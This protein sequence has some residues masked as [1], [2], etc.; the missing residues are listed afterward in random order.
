V[1]VYFAA[2]RAVPAAYS[3][4]ANAAIVVAMMLPFSARLASHS[5]LGVVAGVFGGLTVAALYL[6]PLLRKTGLFSVSSLLAARFPS[7]AP[8]F[9]LIGAVALSSALLAVAGVEIAVEALID[10]AGASRF[11]AA[12]LV[13][14]SSLIIA[15]SGGL[16]GVAWCAAGAAGIALFGLGWPLTALA[17]HGGVPGGLLS[18][19]AGWREAAAL[20]A[21]WRVAPRTESIGVGLGSTLAVAS[22]VASLAPVLAPFV[23]TRAAEDSRRSGYAALF[24]SV[25]LAALAATAVAAAALTLAGAVKGQSA[26]RLPAS[27]YEAGGRGQISI[28]GA[29]VAGASAAQRACAARGLTPGAPLQ[30]A[31]VRPIDGN[32][33]LGALPDATDIGAAASGLLASAVA[34]L[35]LALAAAGLQSCA[36][37]VGHDALYS[38]RGEVDLTSRRLALSRLTLV[39]VSAVAFIIGARAPATSG[40]LIILALAISAACVGPSLIL[41]LIHI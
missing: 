12:F 20:L 21:E 2:G 23:T 6:G 16:A 10:V 9:A 32:F 5:V 37:A 41:S 19:G 14:A 8:R 35:G 38:L 11:L 18:G 40:A 39:A 1:S 36:G 24:W 26:E 33:L 4:F 17:L 7:P 30:P 15:G 13:S 27:I 28:C 3:G 31:D 25:A 29:Y 34:A 22:G